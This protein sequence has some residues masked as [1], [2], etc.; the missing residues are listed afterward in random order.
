MGFPSRPCAEQPFAEAVAEFDRRVAADEAHATTQAAL[1]A[2]RD[3][4]DSEVA[5]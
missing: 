3:E 5:L 2:E 1:E 4:R